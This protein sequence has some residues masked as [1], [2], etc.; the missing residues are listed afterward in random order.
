M[1]DRPQTNMETLLVGLDAGCRPVL[2]P[3]FESGALP[4]LASVFD[5][6]A[7]GPLES[8]IPPWTPSAWPSLYTGVNPGKHGVF[9][10]LTFDGYDWDVVNATH[11]RERTLWDLLDYHGKSS[12]VVN[13]PVTHPPGE[14]DGAIVPG[15]TAP[16]DPD[17]HPD[18][19]LDEI[20]DE[21]GDYR[22]Y[23]PRDAEGSEKVAW[24]EQ[25]IEMRGEAF[26]YLA[27]RFDPEFGFVQF[28]QTDTV[29]HEFPGDDETVR[30]VY[31]A[32]DEQVG[33]ILDACDPDTVIVA[34]DHGMGEYTGHEFRPNEYLRERGLVETTT[35][36]QGMPTWST[37]ADNQLQDGKEGRKAADGSDRPSLAERAVTGLASAGVT[38]QRVYN[39]L[40]AVGLAEFAARHVPTDVARAGSEQVDFPDS[41]AYVRDRIELGVRINLAGREPEGVVPER[42]Y[43]RLCD[44][45][46]D[47]LSAVETPDGKPVFERVARRDEVFSGPYVEEAPDVITVPREFDEFLSTRVGDGQ[48][49]PPSEPYNH[50]RD[51]IVAISGEGATPS[52]D[53]SDAHLFDVAPTILATMGVPAAD[54]MDGSVLPAV[55]SAGTESYPALDAG[56]QEATD[57]GDVEARLADL[58]YLE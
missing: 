41:K 27:S 25:L 34:S 54:R 1:A 42:E 39:A 10:F 30:T 24:Y 38:S 9:G 22:V 4:N 44:D 15:Y 46:V 11:V 51:G 16:E 58:G 43:D 56:E 21:I 36:G 55:R 29:F 20:R 6:G 49:G 57:D 47:A 8:Q 32:V 40:D 2:D 19:L 35:E 23:A 7:A 28:Q 26:R 17:C 52:A 33:E 48:F 31:E 18:G 14:I 13:A 37:I 50:K 3:L 5:S 53:L 45:L 12:V